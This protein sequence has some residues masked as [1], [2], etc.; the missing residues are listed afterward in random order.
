MAGRLIAIGAFLAP[1]FLLFWL[2]A[3]LATPVAGLLLAGWP[4]AIR[5]AEAAI[6]SQ[7]AATFAAGLLG[8]V[9][10]RSWRCC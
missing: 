9:V 1:A 2:G 3:G 6:R 4:V 5:M 7:P 8:L 10:F